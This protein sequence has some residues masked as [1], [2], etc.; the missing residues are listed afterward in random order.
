[1]QI[2]FN[3]LILKIIYSLSGRVIKHKLSAYL[4][5]FITNGVFLFKKD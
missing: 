2:E 5:K 3:L 1:M 4:Y